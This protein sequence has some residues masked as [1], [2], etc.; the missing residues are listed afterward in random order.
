MEA[1]KIGILTFHRTNN[2]GACLQAVATRFILEKMGHEAFYVDYWPAYHAAKYDILSYNKLRHKHSIGGMVSC[3]LHACRNL[4]QKKERIHAFDAFR[5]QYILPYCKPVT[6]EFDVILYGSDQ[7]WRKH[8]TIKDYNPTYFGRNTIASK[9]HIAFAASMGV[10]PQNEKDRQEVMELVSH[11]DRIAVREDNLQQ[12]LSELGYKD[13]RKVLDPTLLLTKD[14]WNKKI[15]IPDYNGHPYVLTYHVAELSFDMDEVEKFAAEKG[16]DVKILYGVVGDKPQPGGYSAADP[17]TF[18]TLFKHAS[19]TF[20]SSF[21]GLAFS[22]IFEKEFLV[23]LRANSNRAETVLRLLGLSD[24]ML[25]PHTEI[26]RLNLID[27]DTVR[28]ILSDK[29]N[30]DLQLLSSWINF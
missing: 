13:V 28:G 11:L 2:Y 16:C 23:S 18:L 12:L 4:K 8:S 22:I 25:K 24:R 10:L 15:A 30:K 1:L 27:Y 6:D 19:Y 21:H 26:P 29:R 9:L 14:D 7:I 3:L 20:V 17:I 5:S